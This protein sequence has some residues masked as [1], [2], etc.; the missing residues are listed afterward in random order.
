MCARK[1][2]VFCVRTVD[3]FVVRCRR[4]HCHRQRVCWMAYLRKVA[5]ADFPFPYSVVRIHS[6]LLYE[7]PIETVAGVIFS[8]YVRRT[9]G[10]VCALVSRCSIQPVGID[11]RAARNLRMNASI[12]S[13][14]VS[15]RRLT[16][17]P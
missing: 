5:V 14:D 1:N 2:Q 7:R 11:R 16:M 4:R 13:A 6:T 3:V 15:R 12:E 8:V 17:L 9:F 10:C